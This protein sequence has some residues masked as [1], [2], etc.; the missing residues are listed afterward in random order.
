MSIAAHIAGTRPA[1]LRQIVA[2]VI[3]SASD[4]AKHCSATH[5]SSVDTS[6]TPSLIVLVV[7]V[8]VGGGDRNRTDE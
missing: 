7:E 6:V 2:A 8:D 5:P 1:A 3:L 4:L